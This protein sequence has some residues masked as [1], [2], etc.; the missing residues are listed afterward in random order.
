MSPHEKEYEDPQEVQSLAKMTE[1][2]KVST[3]KHQVA[4]GAALCYRNIKQL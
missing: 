2:V 1:H 4:E 3:E